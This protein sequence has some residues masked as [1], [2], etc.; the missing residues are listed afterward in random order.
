M[1]RKRSAGFIKSWIQRGVWELRNWV[2][3]DNGRNLDL[4]RKLAEIC[5]RRFKGVK[6]ACPFNPFKKG[7]GMDCETI[8]SKFLD[9][10]NQEIREVK[11]LNNTGNIGNN[12]AISA[13]VKDNVYQLK[14]DLKNEPN[15]R[16]KRTDIYQP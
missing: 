3:R 6:G 11:K 7:E 14:R 15:S 12:L 9:E 10:C 1:K 4:I 5:K 8:F 13:P 16:S 2:N